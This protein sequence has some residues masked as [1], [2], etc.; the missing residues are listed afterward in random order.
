MKKLFPYIFVLLPFFSFAQDDSSKTLSEVVIRSYEQNR[1]LKQV[2]AAINYISQSRLQQFSNASILPAMNSTPG[3]KMEER[4]PASYRINIRGSTLRAP[5]GVRNVKVYWNGIPFTDAGGNTYLNQLSFFDFKNIEIIKGPA[6]SLY[7]AGT[8]GAILIN[9]Q[10]PSRQQGFNAEISGGSFGLF[11]S[12]VETKSGSNSW[13]NSFSYSHQSSNGFRK[14]TAMHRDVITGQSKIYAGKKDQIKLDVLYSDLYYQTPGALTLAEFKVNPRAARPKAGALPSADSAKAAI[15]QQ[16][17]LSAIQNDI[18]F[19]ENFSNSTV[20]YGAWT[21][22]KNP[23]FRNYEKRTEPHFGGR[24]V[25]NW[26]QKISNSNLQVNFGAEAQKGFFNTKDYV[27]ANGRPRNIQTNDDIR[28]ATISLFAQADLQ[29]PKDLVVTVGASTNSTSIKINRLSV[30]NFTPVE[31]KFR[32]ELAPRIAFSKRVI[33][34]LWWYGSIAKGFSPPAVAEV[35]PSTSV[36][37]KDLQPEE[38][39]NYESGFKSSWFEKRLY[40]EVNAFYF[41]LH[42]AIVSRKDAS[43]ADFFINAGSTRQKGIESQASYQFV[44]SKT[45]IESAIL[46]VADTWNKFKY[47]DFKQSTTDFSGKKMP[48]AAPQ[49]VTASFNIDTKPGL[50]AAINYFYS[51]PIPLNDANTEFAHSYNLLG[52][53][54]GWRKIKKSF[55]TNIYA[56][57]ENIFNVIYSLGN[58]INAAGGRYYNVAPG[59]S[60][61]GGISF[62][63]L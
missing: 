16:T 52:A 14:H 34:D 62:R 32:N 24:T 35:L 38:G 36:I 51:D 56:G 27:N 7:G 58:D 44:R 15:F 31:R 19:S 13:Q 59:R 26:K 57:A 4:S 54:L 60:F 33:M 28:P 8:G 61:Y 12:N 11:N 30:T 45:F 37:S 2:P 41:R 29:L 49:V 20:F 39:V 6:S 46:H 21:E 1:K 23:T 43:N 22:L 3:V 18:Y 63:F 42:N 9:A 50:S 10:S 17:W 5:F 48:S 47:D 53:R 55:E 40:L 25:F